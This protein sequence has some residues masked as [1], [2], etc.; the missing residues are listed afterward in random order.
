MEKVFFSPFA[1]KSLSPKAFVLAGCNNINQQKKLLLRRDRESRD[2]V[3]TR[4]IEESGA[5]FLAF[6]RV[7]FFAYQGLACWLNLYVS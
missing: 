2:C 7:E 6:F 5:E 1:I 4:L 3:A